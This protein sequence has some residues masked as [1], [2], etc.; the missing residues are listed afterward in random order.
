MKRSLGFIV[1]MSFVL[2]SLGKAAETHAPPLTTPIIQKVLS[3]AVAKAQALGV[4]MGVAIV[5]AGGNLVGFLK[6]EGASVH[7]NY[8][9]QAKAYTAASIRKPT[10][11]SGIP[12]DIADEIASA[13]G[14]RFTKLP[15]GFPLILDGKTIGGIGVGGGNGEQDIAVAKAGAEALK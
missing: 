14:G 12:S 1:A 9:A 13:T 5:D 4:P 3:A 15:G 2:G 10:H 7:T 8:T 11:E 6:M